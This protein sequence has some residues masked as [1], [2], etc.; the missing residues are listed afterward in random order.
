MVGDRRQ[1]PPLSWRARQAGKSIVIM[2]SVLLPFHALEGGP[3]NAGSSETSD[4]AH[5][6]SQGA[7]I[8][9]FPASRR[10]SFADSRSVRGIFLD[11]PSNA[12][13]SAGK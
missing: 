6:G 11:N 5:S 4:R 10:Q 13:I 8:P 9:R 3:G 7:A 1:R 2:T 12:H